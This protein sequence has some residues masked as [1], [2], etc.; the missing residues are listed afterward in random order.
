MIIKFLLIAA[1]LGFGFLMLR[2][3]TLA[4]ATAARRLLGA[5]FVLAGIVAVLMPNA[6]TNVANLVGVRR[7]TD[8][9]LYI[10]VMLFL[11]VSISLYQR[12]HALD[13]HVTDLT[14][15][16]ALLDDPRAGSIDLEPGEDR[17]DRLP[18]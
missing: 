15:H 9:V 7:G 2:R 13:Q 1:A 5:L 3:P 18:T 4:N 10:L 6:V 11:F 16:L 17:R 12:V 8:L 14:R